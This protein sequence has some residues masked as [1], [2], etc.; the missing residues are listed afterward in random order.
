MRMEGFVVVLAALACPLGM[1]LCLWLMA[2]GMRGR[3]PEEE[4]AGEEPASLA[5]LRAEQER[6]AGE[7]A[8]IERKSANGDEVSAANETAAKRA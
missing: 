5:E 6:L 7:I 2:R 8:Q 4:K 3:S 1:G